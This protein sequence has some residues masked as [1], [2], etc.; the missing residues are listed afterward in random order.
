MVHLG[1]GAEAHLGEAENTEVG[2]IKCSCEGVLDVSTWVDQKAW[3][4]Q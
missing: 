2:A 4:S 3:D 1:E